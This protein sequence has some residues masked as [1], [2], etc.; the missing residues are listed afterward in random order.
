MLLVRSLCGIV[1][2]AAPAVLGCAEL[3]DPVQP[4]AEHLRRIDVALPAAGLRCVAPLH[5][6][7]DWLTFLLRSSGSPAAR[8][9]GCLVDHGRAG[10]LRGQRERPHRRGQAPRAANVLLSAAAGV[11]VGR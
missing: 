6:G 8:V 7:A 4:P 10:D 5:D 2:L 1:L 3:D 11:N 9:H